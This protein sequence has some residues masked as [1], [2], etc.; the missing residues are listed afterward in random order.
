[1]RRGSTRF[2]VLLLATLA[3]AAPGVAVAADDQ[4]N[5]DIIKIV[6]DALKSNDPEMQSGVMGIVRSI[7]GPEF[8]KDLAAEL[9]K[10]VPA[11]QVMLLAA[12][13]DRA[14]APAL[15]AVIEASK[16]QEESVRVAAL[17][18]MGQ[19]GGVADVPLLA[20]RAAGAKGA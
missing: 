1:M 7:P 19:L 9:P 12:P 13:G 10:L 3:V 2:S 18:A 6:I 14:D 11:G 8:T 5:Q 4:G 20:E 15:P 17:R 16:S